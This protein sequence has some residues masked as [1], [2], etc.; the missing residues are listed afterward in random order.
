MRL[1]YGHLIITFEGGSEVK[2]YEYRKR[3]EVV[4]TVEVKEVWER[5]KTV[6]R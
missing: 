2:A 3:G 5:V 4:S 1:D 6:S